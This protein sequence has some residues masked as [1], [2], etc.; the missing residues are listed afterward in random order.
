[1][2]ARCPRV[3]AIEILCRWQ[4]SEEPLDGWLAVGLARLSPRDRN[5]AQAMLLGV[6]RQRGLIDWLLGELSTTPLPRLRPEI[7]QA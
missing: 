3:A 6:L 2:P 4:G 5:L 7:L 1:M